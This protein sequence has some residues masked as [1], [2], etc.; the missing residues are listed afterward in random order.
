MANELGL[1]LESLFTIYLG[2]HDKRLLS[3]APTQKF[4][5]IKAI[6]HELYDIQNSLN[7]IGILILSEP[8]ANLSQ[9]VQVACL[10]NR[11][12]TF[13]PDKIDMNGQ[14]LKKSILIKRRY[15]L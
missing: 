14:V 13:Y 11:N 7:D 15:I 5:I 3:Q 9:Y 10:P 6:R 1:N 8:I 12:Q 4:K 2:L